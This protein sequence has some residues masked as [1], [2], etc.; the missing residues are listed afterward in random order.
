MNENMAMGYRFSTPQ[1]RK[2]FPELENITKLFY[3]QLNFGKKCWQ[4]VLISK[5]NIQALWHPH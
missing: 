1:L 2:N 3:S 4:V 5:E